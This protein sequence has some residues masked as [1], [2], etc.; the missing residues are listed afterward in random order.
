MNR[1]SFIKRAAALLGLAFVVPK[2]LIPS[3][4]AVSAGRGRKNPIFTGEIGRYEGVN[5]WDFSTNDSK[6][7]KIWSK[8][9]W[10][11]ALEES[12]FSKLNK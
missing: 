12:Y 9:I 10:K 7:V 5:V 8:T 6:A 11:D 3:D 4:V 1:R 2:A